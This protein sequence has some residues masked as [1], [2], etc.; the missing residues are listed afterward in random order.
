MAT[1]FLPSLVAS[2]GQSAKALSKAAT[3]ITKPPPPTGA[4]KT[5]LLKTFGFL[6]PLV[7]TLTLVHIAKA[8]WEAV[9]VDLPALFTCEG[10]WCGGA[11]TAGG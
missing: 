6:L 1:F 2:I 3:A 5:G 10:G 9:A 4:M 8:S 11:R 7:P